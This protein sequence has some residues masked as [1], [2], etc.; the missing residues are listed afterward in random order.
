MQAV[1]R[2]TVRL[3]DPA[4]ACDLL[5]ARTPL[6]K[7]KIKDAMNKGAA[8]LIPVRGSAKRLRRAAPRQAC[9]WA[10]ELNCI[11]MLSCWRVSSPTVR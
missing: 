7:S 4:V 5:A 10:T 1:F 8:W 9:V 6:S 2:F 3:D 11:T